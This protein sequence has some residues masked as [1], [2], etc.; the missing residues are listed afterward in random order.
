MPTREQSGLY[1]ELTVRITTEQHFY[2]FIV[3]NDRRV[4][5]FA[6]KTNRNIFIRAPP[7]GILKF[8]IF[9]KFKTGGYKFEEN[10]LHT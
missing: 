7:V 10:I 8:L 2:T 3:I 6:K 9:S 4:F 5:L 1:S